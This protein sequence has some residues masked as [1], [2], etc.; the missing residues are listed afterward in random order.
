MNEKLVHSRKLCL[1]QAQIFNNAT[2]CLDPQTFPHIVYHLS[3]LALEEIGKAGLLSTQSLQH[4]AIEAEKIDK[5]L[6]SHQKKLLW[7]LWSPA[8]RIDPKDFENARRFANESHDL[9]LAS[10]YV[11]SKAEVTA[12]PPFER[13]P[14]AVAKNISNLAKARLDIERSRATPTG[15][16]P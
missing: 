8:D 16:V 2:D 6:D 1:D 7:A 9:R 11:D 15:Q 5:W 12:P 4:E 14:P 13:V 10:L 3:L